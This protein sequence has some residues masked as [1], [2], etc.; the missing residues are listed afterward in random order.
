MIQ[1]IVQGNFIGLLLRNFFSCIDYSQYLEATCWI[2]GTV[3]YYLYGTV[4]SLTSWN[5]IE[6]IHKSLVLCPV[7]QLKL[8]HV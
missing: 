5:F 4:Y 1:S 2:V 6:Q 3:V 7:F 8:K